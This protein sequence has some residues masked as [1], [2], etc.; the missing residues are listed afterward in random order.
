MILGI[1]KTFIFVPSSS[2]NLSYVVLTIERQKHLNLFENHLEEKVSLDEAYLFHDTKMV[3][4][5]LT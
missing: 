1:N 3:F 2:S 4:I 5:S